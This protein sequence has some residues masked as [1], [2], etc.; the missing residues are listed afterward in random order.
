MPNEPL[1]DVYRTWADLIEAARTE[2]D[3]WLFL[4]A[5]APWA[6]RLLDEPRAD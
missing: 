5:S 4:V 2:E 3:A 1:H 6:T